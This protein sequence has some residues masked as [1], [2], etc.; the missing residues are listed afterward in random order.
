MS[1]IRRYVLVDA[2]DNEQDYEFANYQDAYASAQKQNM[3][4]IAR[5]YEYS[6]SELVWT[7]TGSNEWPDPALKQPETFAQLGAQV[8][9]ERHKENEHGS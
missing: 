8:F 4:I 2:D 6:D 9:N 5:T 1:E 3:A 7:P